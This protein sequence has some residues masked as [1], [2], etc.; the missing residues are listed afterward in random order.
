MRDMILAFVLLAQGNGLVGT[1]NTGTNNGATNN[2]SSIFNNA[3][4][5]AYDIWYQ[6]GRPV[7]TVGRWSIDPANLRRR[8]FAYTFDSLDMNWGQPIDFQG[9]SERT[10]EVD[11]SNGSLMEWVPGWGM[12]SNVMT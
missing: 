11:R 6:D 4:P 2:N 12:A 8:L 5:H 7:A 10:T 1:S 3:L 9:R